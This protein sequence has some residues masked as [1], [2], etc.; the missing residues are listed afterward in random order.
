VTGH[1]GLQPT[2]IAAEPLGEESVAS[3]PLHVPGHFNKANSNGN[4]DRNKNGRSGKIPDLIEREQV[5]QTILNYL[6]SRNYILL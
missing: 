4:R 2:Q 1:R 5:G 6:S 3:S